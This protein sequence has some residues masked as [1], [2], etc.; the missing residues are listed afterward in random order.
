MKEPLQHLTEKGDSDK[1]LCGRRTQGA[2]IELDSHT[3]NMVGYYN[4]WPVGLSRE[5]CLID[6]EEHICKTCYKIY[7]Y[8]HYLVIGAMEVDAE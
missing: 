7:M 1:T 3:G 4:H 8:Y 6:L 5:A 2:T